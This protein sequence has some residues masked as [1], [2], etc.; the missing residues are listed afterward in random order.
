MARTGV[1]QERIDSTI[2]SP[3]AAR[4]SPAKRGSDIT[5][6]TMQSVAERTSGSVAAAFC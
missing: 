2:K 3:T 5:A 1:R 4:G 6:R